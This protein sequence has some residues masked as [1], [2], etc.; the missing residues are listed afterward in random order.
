MVNNEVLEILND[1]LYM[2]I[3]TCDYKGNPWISNAFYAFDNNLNL[4]WYSP[5]NSKHSK[6]IKEN[7]NV[8]INIFNSTA[9]GD[10]VKAIYMSGN[11]IELRDMKTISNV[12][13]IYSKFLIKRK[14][15]SNINEITQFRK[16][17]GDFRNISPLRFYKFVPEK[18]WLLAPSIDF[19]GKYVDSRIEVNI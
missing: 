11:A 15:F 8:A 3:S 9:V 10:D 4:Y 12:I 5:K 2:S 14:F 16:R 19:N 17:V 1:N 18:V 6:L 13:L 7:S